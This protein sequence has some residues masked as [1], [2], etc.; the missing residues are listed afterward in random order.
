MP[1]DLLQA[2]ALQNTL[3]KSLP[4]RICQPFRIV[5]LPFGHILTSGAVNSCICESLSTS[6][7]FYFI[8]ALGIYTVHKRPF[9]FDDF[10]PSIGVGL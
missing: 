4:F 6:Y 2:N 3:Y 8:E 10:C 5:V 1:N 7:L 9:P